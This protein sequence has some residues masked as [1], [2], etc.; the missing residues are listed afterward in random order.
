MEDQTVIKEAKQGVRQ[1][2]MEPNKFRILEEGQQFIAADDSAMSGVAIKTI[3]KRMI[4]V[5]HDDQFAVSVIWADCQ[6]AR[7]AR[8]K[9]ALRNETLYIQRNLSR[10]EDDDFKINVAHHMTSNQEAMPAYSPQ[11]KFLGWTIQNKF[12]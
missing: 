1:P 8:N 6:A 4:G 9:L 5:V 2:A 10:T 3:P 12:E 11:G 7:R